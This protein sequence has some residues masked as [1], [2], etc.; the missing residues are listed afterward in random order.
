MFSMSRI[1]L[2]CLVCLVVFVASLC[3]QQ[4][5]EYLQWQ[6][7]VF[8]GKSKLI[9][10][11]GKLRSGLSNSGRRLDNGFCVCVCVCV[12]VVTWLCQVLW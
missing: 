3:V 11:V 6:K 9:V 2:V 10:A 7:A 12:C 1:P 8:F 4:C 5:K